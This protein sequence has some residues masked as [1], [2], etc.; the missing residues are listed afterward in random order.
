ML[1]LNCYKKHFILIY[2]LEIKSLE[3]TTLVSIN[4]F[5]LNRWSFELCTPKPHP[6]FEQNKKPSQVVAVHPCHSKAG[7]LR[8]DTLLRF[9]A[10]FTFYVLLPTSV[11]VMLLPASVGTLLLTLDVEFS[12]SIPPQC[13]CRP[14]LSWL[15][16]G[17]G[18]TGAAWVSPRVPVV[19]EDLFQQNL[20]SN[21]L[22]IM[23]WN[24]K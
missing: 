6:T 18:G 20:P 4:C 23:V 15:A 22:L 9:S 16:V 10:A 8:R 2:Q 12:R 7:L 11:G 19:S 1:L 5:V 17:F 14:W 21:P 3:T 13:S 24:F